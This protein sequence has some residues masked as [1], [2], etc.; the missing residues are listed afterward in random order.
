MNAIN[1]HT[2]CFLVFGSVFA[3]LLFNGS[4]ANGFVLATAWL[5]ANTQ[6]LVALIMRVGW[7]AQ[8]C[9]A[10]GER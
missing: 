3:R 5:F 1:I 8:H 4:V 6:S 9:V 10:T 2:G 7:E